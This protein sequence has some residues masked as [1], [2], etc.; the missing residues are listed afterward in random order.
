MKQFF[1]NT[2]ILKQEPMKETYKFTPKYCR[3]NKIAI[4]VYNV[5]EGKKLEIYYIQIVHII[6]F[7]YLHIL[8][9][10]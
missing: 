3:G 6:L 8:I 9:F 7:R 5:Y 10:V 1:I 4:R 2:Y